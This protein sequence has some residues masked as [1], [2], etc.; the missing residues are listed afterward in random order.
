LELRAD[1]LNAFNNPNFYYG[2]SASSS[3]A[4][5]TLT[6]TTFGRITSAY[7][8]IS[9][10]DDPGGRILQLVARVNF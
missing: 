10:T 5:K 2:G 3:T 1:L 7:Q 9:T 6:S 8:D 4:T